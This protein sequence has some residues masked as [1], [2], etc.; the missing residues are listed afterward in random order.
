MSIIK[1]I[2]IKELA[3]KIDVSTTAISRALNGHRNI[4][5]KTTEK[6]IKA[7][8][9]YNYFPDLSAKRLASKKPDT[10]AFIASIDP[11]AQDY[12][13]MEFLAGLTIGVKNKSTELI[14]KLLSNEKTEL[15]YYKKLI[16]LNIADKFVF[17]RTKKNDG[18]IKFLQKNNI[19][20]VSWGRSSQSTDYAWMDLDNE[21]SIYILM[22]RLFDFGHK[23]I[24]FINVDQSFN[25]GF[26]R[27]N[28]Y[29]K[30]HKKFNIP[31]SSS[32]YQESLDS[33]TTTGIN[34]TKKL[35]SLKNPPTAIICSLDKYFI[36]C[37]QVCQQRGLKIG[38]DI[39]VVGFNDHDNYL[40]NQNLT[41]IS[42]PLKKMGRNAVKILENLENGK[43]P[44]KESM[45]IDP[46]LHRGT[47]D[48][49][50]NNNK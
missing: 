11:Y 43:S 4:S 46:I 37:L 30:F 17:Y 8:K 18:R 28:S 40:S 14:V 41:Y 19:N 10:I 15:A 1:K 9:K 2:T 3:K 42:H 12:V 27:K 16:E 38:K 48:K 44:E 13:L 32:Y 29:E 20:F 26:Q 34:L 39:A 47:L 21:K 23:K 36:G 31:Y 33:R 6:I 7:A 5:K 22:K 49:L 50:S 25:Y 45:L 24:G 35:L